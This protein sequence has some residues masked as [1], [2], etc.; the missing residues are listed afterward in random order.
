M[1]KEQK[2]EKGKDPF[3]RLKHIAFQMANPSETGLNLFVNFARFQLSLEKG[4]LFWDSKFDE[5][6]DEQIL[7]EYYAILMSKS[8]EFRQECEI[9]FTEGVFAGSQYEDDVS[10]MEKMVEQNQRERAEQ[11]PMEFDDTPKTLGE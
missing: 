4:I 11:E 10:W 3:I 1:S 9:L 7:I 2:L 8:E 5:Y 6:T